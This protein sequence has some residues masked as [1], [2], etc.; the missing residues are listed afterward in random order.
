MSPTFIGR[1]QLHDYAF[2]AEYLTRLR[3]RDAGTL[4]HFYDFFY[5]PV[6]NK[7]RHK[8]RW[9]DADD[10]V[11][12]VFV[13][14]LKRIDAGE[15][16][17]PAKLPSYIFGISRNVL[18][19][20]WRDPEKNTVD[21]DTVVLTDGTEGADVRLDDELQARRL[22]E[23]VRKLPP[24]YR[25]AIERV[26]LQEQRRGD[27]ASENGLSLANLRLRLFRALKRLREEWHSPRWESTYGRRNRQSRQR[28]QERHLRRF[29]PDV[30]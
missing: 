5:L 26:C 30:P 20:H 29:N 21:V 8:C 19:Q 2:D 28:S 25:D 12:D 16:E 23:V 1:N 15:P 10:L 27:F 9:E 4:A 6:R 11:Q 24:K 13:A 22:R 3:A 7:I 17:D 18:L 14:A